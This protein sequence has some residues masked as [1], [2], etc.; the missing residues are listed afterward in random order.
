MARATQA[1]LT[2]L[3]KATQK[4]FGPGHVSPDLCAR[5]PTSRGTTRRVA[6]ECPTR[7]F[8]RSVVDL[9][10]A[11]ELRLRVS[12]I[13]SISLADNLGRLE[14]LRRGGDGPA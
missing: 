2:L 6:I 3:E 5:I 14:A 11:N 7:P 4:P 1:G 9:E 8:A 13:P 10:T 12:S